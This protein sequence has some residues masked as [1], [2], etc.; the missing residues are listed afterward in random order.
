MMRSASSA[1]IAALGIALFGAAVPAAAQQAPAAAAPQFSVVVTMSAKAAAKMTATKEQTVVDITYSGDP[2]AA[3]KKKVTEFG[4][5]LGEEQ[6]KI[7]PAGGTVA[8]VGKGFK[9]A[10]V[11]FIKPGTAKVLVNVFSARLGNADNLLDCGLFEG[12]FAEA[13]AKPI[14]IACKL[15]GEP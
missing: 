3:G 15:I 11:K 12:S 4:I 6:V 8:F 14:A 13:A 7:G 10:E 1:A 9:P 2:N 5:L